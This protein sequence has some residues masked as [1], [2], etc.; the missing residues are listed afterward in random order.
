MEHKHE[1]HN[2][3]MAKNSSGN[4][5]ANHVI[6]TAMDHS[7]MDHNSTHHGSNPLM[8]MEG[9]NHHAMMIA[10]FNKRFYVVLIL[11]IPIMLL[12]NMI[13]Q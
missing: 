7:K 6:P 10:D 4:E 11:T 8:G 1:K 3:G 13:Q 5:H 2:L 9:H 12:S